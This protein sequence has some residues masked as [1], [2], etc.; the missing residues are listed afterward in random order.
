MRAS[1]RCVHSGG[2]RDN[3][4]GGL[5]SP[6]FTSSAYEY[7]DRA[8][9]LYPRYFNTPNQR[10]VVA[11]LCA[12]ESAEDGVLVSSGMA[13]I[14]TAFISLL[15]PGDHVVL[16]NELYG[17]THKFATD[18]LDKL[19]VQ[20]T[21]GPTDAEQLVQLATPQTRLLY[22][23]TPAN[24][25]LGIVD[26]SRAAALCRAR[27]IT[28]VIDNTFASPINQNPLTVG[29]DVVV[30][31]GTKYLG[32][33]SDLCCGVVLAGRKFGESIRAT[34]TMLGGSLNAV[35]CYLLERSLKTLSLR[36]ER[37]TQNAGELALF[38]QQHPRVA[39]VY[40]PGLA[41]HPGHDIARAQMR[42]FGAMLACELAPS[43]G[44]VDAFL[45][46]LELIRPAISLGGVET[47][48]CAPAQTSH[49]KLTAA[50]RARQGISNRLLR[51]SVGIEDVCDLVEDFRQALEK[52]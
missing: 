20:Y 34:A 5:N 35:S 8:E 36:V 40:Y 47:T 33:H 52:G 45:R 9:V 26:L 42:G 22:L 14:S 1:T 7:L 43:A 6:I 12:L 30:H 21:F 37:Q 41:T 32:G 39:R 19:G 4:L 27:G 3:V 23:E 13:A 48:L 38:L 24:P 50:E 31:S 18:I 29:I 17:G 25:L 15:A 51:I 46:R 28:T 10:A 2:F 44:E 11:K 49:A 16:Q